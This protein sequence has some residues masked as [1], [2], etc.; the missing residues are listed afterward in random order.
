MRYIFGIDP[1]RK[2]AVA[3]MDPVSREL[4]GVEDAFS[5]NEDSPRRLCELFKEAKLIV[6]ERPLA[7][8]GTPAQ[9]LITLA[10]S[11][12]STLGIALALGVPVVTPT[13][14][15]WKRSVGVSSDKKSSVAEAV[16]LFN[17][18]G[19]APRHDKCEAMLLAYYGWQVNV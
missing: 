9:S 13:A 3:W 18:E 19:R 17:W 6:I 16:H 11:Y 5:D 8:P 4:V 12:G 7:F 10:T 2:G 1:G 15:Q 14:S